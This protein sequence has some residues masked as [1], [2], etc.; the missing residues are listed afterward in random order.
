MFLLAQEVPVANKVKMLLVRNT[1]GCTNYIPPE[2]SVAT[3]SKNRC[4]SMSPNS[5]Q[6]INLF[7]DVV[8]VE[9]I[10][11]QTVGGRQNIGLRTTVEESEDDSFANHP[12]TEE[13]KVIS[14]S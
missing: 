1:T 8:A 6:F 7:F 14:C 10:S 4:H 3:A 9:Q 5:L 11:N 2:L 13:Q 12:P